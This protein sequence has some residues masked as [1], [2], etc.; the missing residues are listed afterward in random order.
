MCRLLVVTFVVVVSSVGF[1]MGEGKQENRPRDIVFGE[2]ALEL[3]KYGKILNKRSQD[4]TEIEDALLKSDIRDAN[5]ISNVRSTV[6]QD[7]Y[8]ANMIKNFAF[9]TGSFLQDAG[10]VFY[11]YGLIPNPPRDAKSLVLGRIDGHIGQIRHDINML[12]LLLV[13]VR[14]PPLSEA[15]TSLRVELS[16]S[17]KK[18]QDAKKWVEED[19]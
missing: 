13:H 16:R 2:R 17:I 8:N 14:H 3:Y 11:L 7:A 19:S 12:N 15:G 18:F 10:D 9:L 5:M 6:Y 4:L 1:V